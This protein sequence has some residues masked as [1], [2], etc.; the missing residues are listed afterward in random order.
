MDAIVF[1]AGIGERSAPVRKLACAGLQLLGIEIDDGKNEEGGKGA[2]I[3]SKDGSRVKVMVVPT[4]EE[5]CIAQETLR[6]I[7]EGKMSREE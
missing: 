1:S 7:D 3:I 2:R 4:D 5:L 6:V